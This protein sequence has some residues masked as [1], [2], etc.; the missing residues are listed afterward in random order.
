MS[1]L[2]SRKEPEYPLSFEIWVLLA[3]EAEA[4]Q[5]YSAPGDA[6]GLEGM[7]CGFDKR[8]CRDVTQPTCC[9]GQP[10]PA[11]DNDRDRGSTTALE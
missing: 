8:L 1:P 10:S 11:L 2:S 7:P 3:M 4:D 9:A 5:E 6:G